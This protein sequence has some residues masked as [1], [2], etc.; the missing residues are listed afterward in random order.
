MRPLSKEKQQD[1]LS[2]LQK[3]RNLREIAKSLHIWKSSVQRLS[4]KHFSDAKLLFGGSPRKLTNEMKRSNVLSNLTRE[5]VFAAR[6]A[7]KRV[8]IFLEY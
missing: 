8:Q 5:K 4:K 3:D 1:V 7:S 2:L 6:E